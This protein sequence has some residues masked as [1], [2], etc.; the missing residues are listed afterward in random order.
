M[1]WELAVIATALLIIGLTGGRIPEGGTGKSAVES[2]LK[3]IALDTRG[4]RGRGPIDKIISIRSV[5]SS[6]IVK[7][8]SGRNGMGR[9][10]QDEE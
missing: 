8:R 10:G 7:G 6:R 9:T 4:V 3:F 5:G 1:I 2:F